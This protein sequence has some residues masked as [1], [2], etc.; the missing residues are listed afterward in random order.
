MLK[1]LAKCPI[2]AH[3]PVMDAQTEA[4]CR[5]YEE[6]YDIVF[7]RLF[8]RTEKHELGDRTNPVCRFCGSKPPTATFGQAAHAIPQAF[9]NRGLTTGYECDACNGQFGRGIENDLG[10]WTL[11]RR[12]TSRI[13]GQKGIPTTKKGSSG[14][15]CVEVNDRQLEIHSYEDEPIFEINEAEKSL[16]LTL[17]VGSYTPVAV[18]KA[19][20]RIGLTLMPEAELAPFKTALD[21]IQKP[22]HSK[23]L[24]NGA[25]ICHTRQNGPMPPDKLVAILLRRKSG[26]AD[27]PYAHLVLGYGNDVYQVV[28]PSPEMD[29][30]INGKTLSF[31]P[32]PT[33]GGPDPAKYG[34]ATP[35]M[36]DMTSSQVVKGEKIQ[37]R[38]RYDR[39]TSGPPP[40]ATPAG[41][42][43]TSKI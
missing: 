14:G 21:W 30:D 7:Q 38:F 27:V 12:T 35:K 16:T 9:G 8:E 4:A 32:F 1:R 5:Y 28:L 29:K 11:P 2:Q 3:C 6:R 42:T 40:S 26:V 39:M 22:D 18:Y 15:W 13:Y 31:V 33:P 20:V 36:L 19:L 37:I 23:A 25:T 10:I 41:D 17:T 24:I 43:S 34:K